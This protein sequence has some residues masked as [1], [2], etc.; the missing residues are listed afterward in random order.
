MPVENRIKKQKQK[1]GKTIC[2][3]L[4]SIFLCGKINNL[5]VVCY[6]NIL[7]PLTIMRVRGA[8]NGGERK[9]D[10][11]RHVNGILMLFYIFPF[12]FV[13][14]IDL[15]LGTKNHLLFCVRNF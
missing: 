6:V 4:F 11:M 15:C 9:R 10:G 14:L 5:F 7:K 12:L 3:P 2:F 13:K 1:N 8:E